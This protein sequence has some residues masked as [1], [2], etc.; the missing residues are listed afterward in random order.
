MIKGTLFLIPS[1]LDPDSGYRWDTFTAE[2]VSSLRCF[3]VEELRTAR[4]LL[5]KEIP[6]FPIDDCQFFLLNEHTSP[7]ALAEM[8]LPLLKGINTGLLSEAGMPA[9][10]DPGAWLVQLC[11]QHSIPVVPMPGP[12]SIMLALAAS[13]FNGQQFRFHGYLPAEHP[14]RARKIRDIEKA[15][16]S[17]ETQIFIETPYRN[18]QL[19]NE[20]VEICNPETLLCIAA[21]LTGAR[22]FIQTSPLKHWK[23]L[24]PD[25]HK[26]PAVFLMGAG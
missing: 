7:D 11:H 13:G 12:T 4:R 1:P 2:I 22:Q 26:L 3:V 8:L 10:A 14:E 15:T 5:R 19:L 9:V 24:Q 6:Q 17:K 20:I 25:I 21:G 23:S 16:L 18:L